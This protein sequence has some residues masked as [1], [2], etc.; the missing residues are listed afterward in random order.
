[1]DNLMLYMLIY[2]LAAANGRDSALFGPH[3]VRGREAFI[4]S[5]PGNRFPELWFELPLAGSPWFDLHVLTAQEDLPA[6][7]TPAAEFCGGHPEAFRWFAA[8]PNVRQLA[9]SWDLN[10]GG[11]PAAAIQLL[12]DARD[13][14][15]FC[16]FLKA[17]GRPEAVSACQAF[18][19]R[20][21]EGWYPCYSGVFPA[22]PGHH[23]RVECIPA[24][25]LQ[26]AYA[27]D[28]ALLE[29]H[30]S[31]VGITRF[32]STVI[33]RCRYLA[34]LPFQFEFQFDVE[35]SG[36]AG[37]VFGASVR[38]AVA[39][40]TDGIQ[41]FRADG[42]A[43]GLMAEI[44]KWGLA[45]DRWRLLEDTAFAQLVTRR[46]ENCRIFCAPVF[47]K[48]RWRDGEPLDAKAY[49]MAGVPENMIRV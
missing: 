38:F 10:S 39:D 22:R 21:P 26:Q 27:R 5:V 17:A 23:L 13:D 1:M 29:R 48:L 6:G 3:V 31:Q 45:D 4:R 8:A 46:G 40:E 28:P 36:A 11:P 14:R 24:F 37:P 49:L 30:L 33:P 42:A 32:G 15:T 9:L 47:I 25:T 12:M 2:A 41:A 44:E 20:L 7:M 16:D 19:S 35:E 18:L 43:G 34:S